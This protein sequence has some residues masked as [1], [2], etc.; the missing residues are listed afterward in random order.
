MLLSVEYKYSLHSVSEL[1][2]SGTL[3]KTQELKMKT[4]F[5]ILVVCVV[6]TFALDVENTDE[7]NVKLIGHENDQAVGES[8]GSAGNLIA[9]NKTTTP[10][11]S[12]V[13]ER[14]QEI[15]KRQRW[16]KQGQEQRQRNISDLNNGERRHRYSPVYDWL[17]REDVHRPHH[18]KYRTTT[19]TTPST[20]ITT[21]SNTPLS[22]VEE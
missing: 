21:T 15:E 14:H 19:T 10:K 9:S 11:Y 22:E 17:K 3:S 8:T 18:H 20:T 13:Y 6:A 12:S 7:E 1:V 5:I 4:Q 16:F 2:N